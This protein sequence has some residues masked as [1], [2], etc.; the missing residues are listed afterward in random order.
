MRLALT[1]AT[2]VGCILPLYTHPVK[3]DGNLPGSP[4]KELQLF[5]PIKKFCVGFLPGGFLPVSHLL[6]PNSGN[7]PILGD[8]SLISQTLL[9]S[10]HSAR[11][12]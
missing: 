4:L 11:D 7:I 8:I 9:N 6:S 10:Q 2:Q 1:R 3:E 12:H 5:L